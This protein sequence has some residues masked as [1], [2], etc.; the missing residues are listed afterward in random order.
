MIV[1]IL[2]SRVNDDNISISRLSRNEILA[3]TKNS[4]SEQIKWD[5]KMKWKEEGIIPPHPFRGWGDF[6]HLISC[7]RHENEK[8]WEIM[9]QNNSSEGMSSSSLMTWLRENDDHN[10]DL[11][12]DEIFTSLRFIPSDG[13]EIKRFLISV[14]SFFFNC[15]RYRLHEWR[16]EHEKHL[17]D[18][19]QTHRITA[20]WK[21][22]TKRHQKI[23]NSQG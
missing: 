3:E 15:S 19:S 1:K 9:R 16:K 20:L 18:S 10:Y 21:K 2:G 22:D 14:I 17:L 11:P 23:N 5:N 8:K 12:D 7:L 13:A 6:S 4:S